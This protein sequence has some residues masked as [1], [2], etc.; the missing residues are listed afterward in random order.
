MVKSRV[1]YKSQEFKGLPK[2]SDFK[3]VEQEVDEELQDD[4]IMTEAV[5]ISVD[6]FIRAYN[7]PVTDPIIGFQTA[8]VLKS[9]CKKYPVG[10]LVLQTGGWQ[11]VRKSK[12]DTI[13]YKVDELLSDKVPLTATVGALGMPGLTAYTGFLNI[14]KPKPGETVMINGCAGAVGSLVGQIA[15]IKGCKVVGCC[16]S[17]KKIEFAKSIGFDAVFNYKT[18]KSWK[19]EIAKV[20]PDGIDCF[21]DNVGGQLSSDILGAMNMNGRIAVCGSISTYN[22]TEVSKA[23]VIQGAMVFKRLTMQGFIVNQFRDDF[24]AGLK[25]MAQWIQEGKLKIQETVTEGFEN[26]PK[27]FIGMLTGENIG[28]AVVKL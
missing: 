14:C 8:K 4:E 18:A 22:D 20:A 3:I 1:Y 19:D 7:V 11:T 13:W 9:K 26:V 6:P 2:L 27:A 21:F 24:P 25:D 16:G 17:D 23:S 15:K 28:K 5:V 10:S 12:G